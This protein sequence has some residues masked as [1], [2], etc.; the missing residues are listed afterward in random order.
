MAGIMP[1]GVIILGAVRDVG[2]IFTLDFAVK[3]LGSDPRKGEKR[4]TGCIEEVVSFGGVSS[5]PGH[6]LY[7]DDDGTSFRVEPCTLGLSEHKSP[8]RRLCS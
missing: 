6:W 2:A 8:L 4:G 5:A 3:A 7:S 1:S